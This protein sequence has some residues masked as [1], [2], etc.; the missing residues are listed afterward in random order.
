MTPLA[1]ETS[2]LPLPDENVFGHRKKL[3]FIRAHIF[4]FVK[5][6]P[7]K[8]VRVL[9]A[10]CSN[11]QFVTFHLGDTG[12]KVVAVDIHEPSIE[13]AKEHNPY[14][15]TITFLATDV[16]SLPAEEKFDIVVLA[17]ILEHLENPGALLDSVKGRLNEGGIIL[18]SI[19]NGYGPFEIENALDRRG[20]LLPCYWM[21]A[22]VSGIWGMLT[23][24]KK[25]ESGKAVDLPY[26]SECTHVQFWTFGRF[27]QLLNAHG[28]KVAEWKK[29]P[30]M[31]ALVTS[32]WWGR[33]GR[34]CRWN[35]CI[36]NSLP[37]WMVSTW[38]FKIEVDD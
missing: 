23:G 32:T 11:G 3:D 38:V 9:D 7:E 16:D 5:N 26:A 6:H 27:L 24:R 13:Y 30:W 35:A 12:A 21:F 8:N 10:G 17:D 36:G 33:S 28:L 14:P 19:P 2:F 1:S 34:F 18:L 20:C 15:E 25:G 22:L 4:D 37:L 31:G 29:G